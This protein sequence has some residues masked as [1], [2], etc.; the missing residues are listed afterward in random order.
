MDLAWTREQPRL[1][2]VLLSKGHLPS[3]LFSTPI[4]GLVTLLVVVGLQL[5][6]SYHPAFQLLS[7]PV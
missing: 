3:P 5:Y 4:H 2:Y 7:F 1:F 6:A